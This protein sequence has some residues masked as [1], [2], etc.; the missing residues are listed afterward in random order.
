MCAVGAAVVAR[1]FLAL[2]SAPPGMYV[3]EA[4]IGYN[5]LAIAQHGVDEHG[6]R[7]PLYFQAFGE[8]KNPVYIYALAALVRFFALTPFLVR[9]PAA[10]FGLVAVLFLTLAAWRVSRSRPGTLFMLALAALTPWLTLESRVGFEVI[11]M[12]AAL[13]A[14]LWCLSADTR[15]SRPRFFAAGVFLALAILAYSTGRLVI[16][17]FAVVIFL[18]Y[19][20]MRIRG[21]WLALLPIMAGYAAVGVWALTHPGALT[22]EFNL[23]NIGA[24]RAPALTV[25][26]RFFSN[27]IGYFSPDFLFIHGD[28][29]PRHNTGY[30][31]MLLAVTAPLLLLGL[32]EC[33]RRRSEPL[34]RFLVL[35]L[36]L[37][38]IPA[39]LTN[40]GGASHALRSAVMLPLLMLLAALGLSCLM[41]LARVRVLTMV[42]AGG[43][44]AQ[45]VLWTADMYTAYPSR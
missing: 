24:D 16:A 1:N 38:P 3:D 35:S 2:D 5:A 39:A 34:P 11:S 28:P 10:A 15:L 32:W 13:S 40:N 8:S 36:L 33:R 18:V 44:I 19:G 25:V 22:E 30:A 14:A 42:L 12:V 29:N 31:G 41:E 26:A 9:V 17:L 23:I 4:S 20:R 7:L 27:Y 6:V 43:L 37:A 45:A 21:W